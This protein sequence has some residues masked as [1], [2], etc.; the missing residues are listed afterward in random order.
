MFYK[1]PNYREPQSLNWTKVKEEIK[2]ALNEY[3]QKLSRKEH[4]HI[5]LYEEWKQTIIEKVDQQI[6][7]LIMT[8]YKSWNSKK[9]IFNNTTVKE[10][11][12]MLKDK[13]VIL[14]I[15]KAGNNI[16]L[17]CKKNYYEI[18][19]NEVK[20]DMYETIEE[21]KEQILEKIRQQC[22]KA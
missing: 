10:E 9:S 1:G 6:M 21:N 8:K 14:P 11:L 20:S 16:G 22:K 3:T 7:Q 13:Y 4:K 5:S 12:N 19:E 18:L 17:M 2:Q 15:D